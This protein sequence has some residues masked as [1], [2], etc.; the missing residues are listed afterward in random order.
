MDGIRHFILRTIAS[1]P[2]QNAFMNIGAASSLSIR[3]ESLDAW[4]GIHTLGI[5]R[6][7]QISANRQVE[8][9]FHAA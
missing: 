7:K 6:G 1:E 2:L 8:E 4:I 9:Q 3:P 5:H